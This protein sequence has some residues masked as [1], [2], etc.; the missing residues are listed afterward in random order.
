MRDP[1]D[2]VI[3]AATAHAEDLLDEL[4]DTLGKADDPLGV[5][6]SLLIQLTRFVA[7]VDRIAKDLAQGAAWLP[8]G[9]TADDHAWSIAIRGL[10]QKT[11]S[12]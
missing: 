3:T 10:A 1:T 12:Q 9:R 5:A 8:T 2:E 4:V 7:E 11:S 6:R